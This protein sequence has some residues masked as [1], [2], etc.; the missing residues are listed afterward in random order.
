MLFKYSIIS[1]SVVYIKF[2]T[3][4]IF[5]PS[6]FWYIENDFQTSIFKHFILHSH[7]N[8]KFLKK[9]YWFKK[10]NDYIKVYK[11]WF[12]DHNNI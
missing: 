1:E 3:Y 7:C 4:K 8:I 9:N 6:P 10:K 2:H 11:I 12:I 5:H